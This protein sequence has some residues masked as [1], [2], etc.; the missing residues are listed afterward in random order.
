MDAATWLGGAS[1]D[2]RSRPGACGF[3]MH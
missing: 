1:E 2:V 3:V